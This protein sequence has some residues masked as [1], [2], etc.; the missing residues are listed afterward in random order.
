MP[1]LKF[2]NI[3][4]CSYDPITKKLSVTFVNGEVWTFPGIRVATIEA[5][6]AAA[7]AGQP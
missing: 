6:K 3:N 7:A 4:M 2:R 1:E 5:L